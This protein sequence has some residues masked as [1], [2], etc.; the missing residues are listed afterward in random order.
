MKIYKG[1]DFV[2]VPD[3]GGLFEARVITSGDPGRGRLS[4]VS[5]VIVLTGEELLDLMQECIKHS[6]LVLTRD[7]ADKFLYSKLKP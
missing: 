3:S 2:Y 4:P 1:K 6:H 5:D 7:A